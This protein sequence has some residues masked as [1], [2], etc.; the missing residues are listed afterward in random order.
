ASL[1]E[2]RALGVGRSVGW[3]GGTGKGGAERSCPSPSNARGRDGEC[4]SSRDSSQP[5]RSLPQ[6]FSPTFPALSALRLMRSSAYLMPFALYGSGTRSER[7]FA[8]ISPT[9]C[10]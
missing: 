1:S 10:L 5:C 8:A 6:A 4:G 7:I 2:A 3:G 9:A